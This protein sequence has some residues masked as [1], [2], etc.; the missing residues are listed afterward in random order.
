MHFSIP[1]F[2]TG[3]LL[4]KRKK[5][6]LCDIFS[7]NYANFSE[8]NSHCFNMVEKR[9]IAFMLFNRQLEC[10]GTL[11]HLY[12]NQIDDFRVIIPIGFSL[13]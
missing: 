8:V 2:T 6:N 12:K 3:L 10:K 4:L 7:A 11:K 9:K 1:F 13:E 5:K